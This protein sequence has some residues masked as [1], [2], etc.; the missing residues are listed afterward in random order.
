MTKVILELTPPF[1]IALQRALLYPQ[2]V[3]QIQVLIGKL[4][5]CFALVMF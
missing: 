3:L 2:E 1:V 5:M 4:T